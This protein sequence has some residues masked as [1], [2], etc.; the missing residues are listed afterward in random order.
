MQVTA[1]PRLRFATVVAMLFTVAQLWFAALPAL[2]ATP[3]RAAEYFHQSPFAGAAA[4]RAAD[5]R[6]QLEREEARLRPSSRLNDRTMRPELSEDQLRNVIKKFPHTKW[7]DL[8]AYDLLD[9]KL[10]GD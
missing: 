8:A 10:C 6:W 5:I 2:A 3:E 9:N 1:L 7:A 4:F